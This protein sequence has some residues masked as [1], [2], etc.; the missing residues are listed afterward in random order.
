MEGVGAEGGAWVVKVAFG[1]SS[2]SYHPAWWCRYPPSRTTGVRKYSPGGQRLGTGASD[3]DLYV[4]QMSPLYSQARGP[5][6]WRNRPQ[7]GAGSA[8]A[9]AAAPRSL[10]EP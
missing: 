6:L 3:W 1:D 9:A 2:N 5:L 7:E 4:P 8:A 10:L